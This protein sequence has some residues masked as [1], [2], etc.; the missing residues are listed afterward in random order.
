[1]DFSVD[2]SVCSQQGFVFL[3]RIVNNATLDLSEATLV[4]LQG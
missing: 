1:M 3:D 4:F 2:D